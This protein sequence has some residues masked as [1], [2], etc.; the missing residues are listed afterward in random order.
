MT[1]TR[2]IAR[3]AANSTCRLP[4]ATT[5]PTGDIVLAAGHDSGMGVMNLTVTVAA[6]K[7]GSPATP[8]D[9]SVS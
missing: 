3:C 6:L 8:F 4:Q 7:T 1:I 5:T 2:I 9:F